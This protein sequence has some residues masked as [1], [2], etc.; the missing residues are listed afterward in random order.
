MLWNLHPWRYPKLDYMQ[1]Q[2]ASSAADPALH[3]EIRVGNLQGALPTYLIHSVILWKL[4][5]LWLSLFFFFFLVSSCVAGCCCQLHGDTHDTNINFPSTTW[6]K[7]DQQ[8]VRQLISYSQAGFDGSERS[9]N[10]AATHLST[11]FSLC[12]FSISFSQHQC[13]CTK[14]S[15]N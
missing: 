12:T 3:R 13:W 8:Q 9:N 10:K 5:V 4:S 1:S 7:P 6:V 15:T 2:A 11:D 14:T